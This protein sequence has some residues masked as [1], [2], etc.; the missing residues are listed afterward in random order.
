MF[1]RIH[2]IGQLLDESN[3]TCYYAQHY[4][5][6]NG[7]NRSFLSCTYQKLFK[8]YPPAFFF[9]TGNSYQY[10]QRQ[11]SAVTSDFSITGPVKGLISKKELVTGPNSQKKNWSL[12]PVQTCHLF[13]FQQKNSAFRQFLC[14]L[15]VPSAFLKSCFSR[16]YLKLLDKG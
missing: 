14:F 11:L 15:S 8:K 6:S 9:E 13:C 5:L 3:L 16:S 10:F 12:E 4:S 2:L 7:E 1:L